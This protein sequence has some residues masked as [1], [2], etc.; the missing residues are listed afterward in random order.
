MNNIKKTLRAP[1]S[2]ALCIAA[3]ALIPD[4]RLMGM[5]ECMREYAIA[6]NTRKLSKG[7]RKQT[8]QNLKAS[9]RKCQEFAYFDETTINNMCEG[10]YLTPSKSYENSTDIEKLCKT[11]MCGELCL[12]ELYGFFMSDT[13][14]SELTRALKQQN[15]VYSFCAA[16][17]GAG[18]EE[19]K[20]ATNAAGKGWVKAFTNVTSKAVDT[21][22]KKD[23]SGRTIYYVIPGVSEDVVKETLKEMCKL[24]DEVGKTVEEFADYCLKKEDAIK[25]EATGN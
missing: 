7:E 8:F 23:S 10:K 2:C 6:F 9:C 16:L 20:E 21:D 19:F 25:E 1:F 13:P 15:G 5:E 18:T 11:I 17:S 3:C 4:I 24:A 22:F 12:E 14:G